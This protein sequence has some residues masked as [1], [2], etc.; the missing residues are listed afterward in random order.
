MT[1]PQ[2]DT[3]TRLPGLTPTDRRSL[4]SSLYASANASALSTVLMLGEWRE[5]KPSPLMPAFV[6]EV[7]DVAGT[8]TA[9]GRPPHYIRWNPYRACAVFPRRRKGEHIDSP[10][11]VRRCIDERMERLRRGEHV[12]LGHLL[13]GQKGLARLAALHVDLDVGDRG[14]KGR[15]PDAV[16]AWD[17]VR[18]MMAGGLLPAPS[19]VGLSGR[20]L[21]LV[22]ALAPPNDDGHGI[23]D[24]SWANMAWF[25]VAARRLR[26]LCGNPWGDGGHAPP[27]VSRWGEGVTPSLNPDP[28]T[29][30][31]TQPFKTP[32]APH[33][34]DSA[35]G[36]IAYYRWT[37]TTGREASTDAPRGDTSANRF[38][39]HRLATWGMNEADALRAIATAPNGKPKSTLTRQER[40][41]FDVHPTRPGN[42]RRGESFLPMQRRLDD[43]ERLAI[44]RG[45]VGE[46]M[47]TV[48][49][50]LVASAWFPIL[51]SRR[52]G[53]GKATWAEAEAKAWAFNQRHGRPPLTREEFHVPRPLRFRNQ[54]IVE[55]LGI[56]DD[57]AEAAGLR[58]LVPPGVKALR[59]DERKAH[60]PTQRKRER[61]AI[62]LRQRFD[63]GLTIGEIARQHGITPRSVKRVTASARG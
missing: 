42:Y 40:R 43:L 58:W 50:L 48:W 35:H 36:R 61:N 29:A 8:L 9:L 17:I 63:E 7:A 57:E 19:F 18:D 47:R 5:G 15:F 1:S 34:T 10:E 3:P 46:G 11:A 41:A 13:T 38:T 12:H 20:G 52:P 37:G 22:Y 60:A 59:E 23:P 25:R 53:E 54:T 14:A 28:M 51:S 55:R 39:L 33:P 56:T 4:F 49:A 21:S 6:H 2:R 62:I 31:P 24:A 44:H 16:D 32:D 30:N 26:E 27:D 45:G